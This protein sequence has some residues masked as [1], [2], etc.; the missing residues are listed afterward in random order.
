MQADVLLGS[1]R[2]REVWESGR[3]FRGIRRGIRRRTSGI[4]R[5]GLEGN[6]MWSLELDG[7]RYWTRTS[8]LHNVSVA[9]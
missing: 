3:E 9:L 6:T 4:T 1:Q 7:G 5:T 2:E 8:D